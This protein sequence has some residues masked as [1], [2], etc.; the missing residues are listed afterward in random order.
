MHK[1]NSQADVEQDDHAD[2]DCVW[3]LVKT[4]GDEVQCN[5][6]C[7][8]DTENEIENVFQVCQIIS[9]CD[10][11]HYFPAIPSEKLLLKCFFFNVLVRCVKKP[12]VCHIQSEPVRFI[13]AS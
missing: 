5:Q 11:K 7:I 1:K 13:S 4:Q 3:A 8:V 9:Y 10:K 6:L 12:R 2:H